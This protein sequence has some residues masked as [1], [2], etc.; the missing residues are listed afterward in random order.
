MQIAHEPSKSPALDCHVS[1]GSKGAGPKHDEHENHFQDSIAI[2]SWAV[3]GVTMWTE[4]VVYWPVNLYAVD[5][6]LINDF[7]KMEPRHDKQS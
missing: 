2:K 5:Y 4:M 6:T 1:D 7:L 3:T